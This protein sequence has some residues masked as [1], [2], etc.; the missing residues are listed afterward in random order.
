MLNRLLTSDVPAST[1]GFIS[2]TLTESDLI[3]QNTGKTVRFLLTVSD[4]VTN[5]PVIH[6]APL[7]ALLFEKKY[8]A[9]PL[10]NVLT[11]R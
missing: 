3:G 2:E 7:T 10:A 6:S 1:W 5:K 4:W 11:V 9:I 8:Y